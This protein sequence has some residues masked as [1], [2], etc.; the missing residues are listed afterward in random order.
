MKIH[1]NVFYEQKFFIEHMHDKRYLLQIHVVYNY[2]Y[3]FDIVNFDESLKR[4]SAFASLNNINH[5][6]N[7]F[8]K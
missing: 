5:K 2:N 3:F 6:E 7:I 1:L 4:L 8:N